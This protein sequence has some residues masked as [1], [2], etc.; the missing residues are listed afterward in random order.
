MD[1]GRSV[2]AGSGCI[3][4]VVVEAGASYDVGLGI[5]FAVQGN[6]ARHQIV[7]I[8]TDSGL[9]R[10]QSLMRRELLRGLRLLHRVQ[11]RGDDARWP[12]PSWFATL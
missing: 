3:G 12:W 4:V 6:S 9:V 10:F 1:M 5:F 2:N 11:R 8:V 7:L